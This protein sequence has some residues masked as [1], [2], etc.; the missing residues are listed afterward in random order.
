MPGRYAYTKYCL[1]K[2]DYY[3]MNFIAWSGIRFHLQTKLLRDD[4]SKQWEAAPCLWLF[5]QSNITIL[6]VYEVMIMQNFFCGSL[7]HVVQKSLNLKKDIVFCMPT[8]WEFVGIV[9]SAICCMSLHLN[10][11]LKTG[12]GPVQDTQGKH[13]KY[14]S[15]SSPTTQIRWDDNNGWTKSMWSLL[16]G[17]FCWCGC[18]A[19]SMIPR[20]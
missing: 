12:V 7:A 16:V 13:K 3:V 6:S 9:S 20:S 5:Y 14:S 11:H 19:V 8:N 4:K 15:S 2:I 1:S 17:L 18:S 10:S